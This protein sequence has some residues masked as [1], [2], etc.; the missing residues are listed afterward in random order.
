MLLCMVQIE[1]KFHSWPDIA[2]DVAKP[3]LFRLSLLFPLNFR[4]TTMFK[5]NKP[6]SNS[7]SK[8]DGISR[9]PSRLPDTP[10]PMQPPPPPEDLQRSIAA[11]D[12]Q[13]RPTDSQQVLDR[14]VE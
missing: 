10:P 1:H 11:L 9:I 2:L 13:T 14:G 4:D 12:S 5:K 8:G 7:T 6:R 3:P